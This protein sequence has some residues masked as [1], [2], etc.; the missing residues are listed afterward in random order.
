[1][2]LANGTIA[3]RIEPEHG[4]KIASFVRTASGR[5][6]LLGNNASR[7]LPAALGDEYDATRSYG[8]DEC[9]PTVAPCVYPDPPFRGALMPDHGDAWSAPS[10]CEMLSESSAR[11]VTLGRA[12]PYRLSKTITL[13]GSSVHLEYHMENVGGAGFFYNWTAHPL[14]APEE[15]LRVELPTSLREPATAPFSMSSSGYAHMS[16]TRKLRRSEGR[17]SAYWPSSGER[18]QF[19]FD[20][21][22]IPYVG[23]W[24]TQGGWPGN[25]VHPQYSVA[26]EPTFAP[27]SLAQAIASGNAPRLEQGAVATWELF[28]TALG[29]Q[30]E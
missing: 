13:F 27:G 12:L 19:R 20:T 15:G 5:E 25:A 26:I 23:I 10:T 8:F 24:V 21:G 7:G 29:P 1:M 28:V 16:F 14:L 30:D 18:I 2:R 22:R 6:F 3:V 17:V 9:V 4:A 11:C